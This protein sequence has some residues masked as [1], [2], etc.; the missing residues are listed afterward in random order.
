MKQV[1]VKKAPL[2]DWGLIENGLDKVI[3]NTL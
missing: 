3:E 2:L 1:Q